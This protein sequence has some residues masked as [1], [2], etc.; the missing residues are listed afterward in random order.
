MRHAADIRQHLA[1][2]NE[3][4]ALAFECGLA[5]DVAYMA[6]LDDEIEHMTAAFVGQSVTE[7]A[8]LR[9]VFDGPLVG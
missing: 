3:E 9:A 2:L 1:L 4:R 5:F 6:D 8:S 7:I